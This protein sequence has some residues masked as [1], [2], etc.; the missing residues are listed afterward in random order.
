MEQPG[1]SDESL[2]ISLRA[3]SRHRTWRTGA[4]RR[5]E[6]GH[7]LP[8]PGGQSNEWRGPQ[9]ASLAGAGLW[10]VEVGLLC[11]DASEHEGILPKGFALNI[12]NNKSQTTRK[13]FLTKPRPCHPK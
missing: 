11:H 7:L 5:L 1:R 12:E 2:C 3:G 8:L 9:G 13:D 6:A 4:Y 10:P